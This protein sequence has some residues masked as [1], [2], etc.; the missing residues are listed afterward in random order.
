MN[1]TTKLLIFI[2]ACYF[3]VGTLEHDDYDS[4]DNVPAIEFELPDD[5]Y[6]GPEADQL[7]EPLIRS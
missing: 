4:L 6:T 7:A 5:D 1:R 3:V 2:I